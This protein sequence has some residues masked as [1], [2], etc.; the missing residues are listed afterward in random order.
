MSEKMYE[1][2]VNLSAADSMVCGRCKG[3]L[4]ISRVTLTYLGNSFPV[5][6]PKCPSC[7]QVFIPEDLALG[8][9]LQVEKSM[10][11]K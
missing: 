4:E 6:L 10:E 3:P 2:G 7:N 5:S 8:K 1:S 11:D 9:M